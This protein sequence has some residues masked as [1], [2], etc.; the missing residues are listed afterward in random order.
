MA[1]QLK[2]IKHSGIAADF[3][4]QKLRQSLL[5]SGADE[6]AVANVLQTIQ[7]Q[8]YDGIATKKIYR[9]AGNLLKKV[10]ASHAAR[11]NL[12]SALQLLGP[13]G[14]F[15]EKFIARVYVHEGYGTLTNLNLQ[16]HCV[17]H[18]IDVVIAKAGRITMVECKFHNSNANNSD[19]KVP[20]YILSRFNDL[21]GNTHSLFAKHQKIDRCLIAT[22]NRFT[23]DAI[24]FANCSGLGLLA[25]DYPANGGLKNKIDNN[26]LY[27]ITCLTTLSAI[28]KEK[29][30]IL[31][32]LLVRE[33]LDN[34]AKLQKIGIS[35]NRE[36]NIIKEAAAL[37]HYH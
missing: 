4:P 18:E 12:R 33:L 32:L 20:M 37:C 25:W 23:A 19:V 24:A 35:A 27:P 36:K 5:R 17:S 9:L 10:S 26:A 3:D 8:L 31:D 1:R 15:F 22:N 34:P 2:V 7:Q 11:Y 6:V 13:A 29:L 14:F 21:K 30:L 28:E 16:G